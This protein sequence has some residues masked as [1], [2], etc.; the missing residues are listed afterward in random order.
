MRRSSFLKK[1]CAVSCECFFFILFCK[2]IQQIYAWQRFNRAQLIQIIRQSKQ[3]SH[4]V[5]SIFYFYFTMC[6]CAFT[7]QLRFI[8]FIS[9]Q[10]KCVRFRRLEIIF[11]RRWEFTQCIFVVRVVNE[12]YQAN[13]NINS[14]NNIRNKVKRQKYHNV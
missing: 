11:N 12:P 1:G 14:S 5:V 7:A 8:N 3:S 10:V 4:F 6:F 2:I 13:D 9:S